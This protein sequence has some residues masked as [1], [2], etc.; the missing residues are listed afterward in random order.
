MPSLYN[1]VIWFGTLVILISFITALRL[2]GKRNCPFYL[3]NFYLFPFLALLVSANTILGGYFHLFSHR[4]IHIIQ[5]LLFILEFLFWYLFFLALIKRNSKSLHFVFM[6]FLV[7]T[8][9][10]RLITGFHN[11]RF[12]IL[13]VTNFG[14]IFFCLIYYNELFKSI[15]KLNLN[16]EPSFW[17]VTGLF[18]YNCISLPIYTI[19]SFLTTNL[20]RLITRNIFA[21]TNIAIIL[22][23]ILFIKAYL[24]QIR[25]HKAL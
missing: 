24:C 19:E 21:T 4:L 10:L 6:L 7:I 5:N 14:N 20:P 15:P 16:S 2:I 18:F 9:L 11:L 25:Q 13:A 1:I 23:H 3:K 8:I 12:E 17:I 22:M